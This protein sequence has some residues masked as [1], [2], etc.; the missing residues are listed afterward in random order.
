MDLALFLNG[1]PPTVP[2]AQQIASADPKS[3]PAQ[4]IDLAGFIEEA[5]PSRKGDSAEQEAQRCRLL[6]LCIGAKLGGLQL[7]VPYKSWDSPGD[8]YERLIAEAVGL[9]L[10]E[11]IGVIDV[12]NIC[13]VLR[14]DYL[15][16]ES[17]VGRVRLIAAC[18]AVFF[19]EEESHRLTELVRATLTGFA[20]F[21]GGRQWYLPNAD[22][23]LKAI[24]TAHAYELYVEGTTIPE[25]AYRCGVSVT[26]MYRAIDHERKRR[27]AKRAVLIA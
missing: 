5:L 21:G 18:A 25:L 4:L 12:E 8:V 19:H 7:Y 22:V 6:V 14:E 9:T 15:T 20:R 13:R 10:D 3:W 16:K 17:W 23:L 26:S 11:A 24:R 1:S 27:R 2:T